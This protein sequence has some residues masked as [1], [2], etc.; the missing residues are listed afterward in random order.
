MRMKEIKLGI[1]K[2]G[3]ID[4]PYFSIDGTAINGISAY[5]VLPKVTKNA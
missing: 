3:V 5:P 2:I 1:T 4:R